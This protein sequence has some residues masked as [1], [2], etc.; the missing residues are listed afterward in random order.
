MA[1][2][3]AHPSLLPPLLLLPLLSADVLKRYI[4][5]SRARCSPK[6]TDEAAEELVRRYQIMR[7]DGR[8]RKVVVATPRQLE[9]FIRIA[10]S[11]ARM[12]LDEKVRCGGGA[13]RGAPAAA[14]VAAAVA[15]A[16]GHCMVYV[17]T[18]PD[19]G[20]PLPGCSGS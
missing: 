18:R 14:A 12:R 13:T 1:Q 11:L 7:R 4:A 16:C 10:E 19:P 20:L 6:L 5:Y 2:G 3:P 15:R 8:E 17:C 9:S